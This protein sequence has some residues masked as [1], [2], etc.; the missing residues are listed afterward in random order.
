[1]RMGLDRDIRYCGDRTGGYQ[2]ILHV[3]NAVVRL[4]VHGSGQDTGE[5]LVV[6]SRICWLGVASSCL[7]VSAA[8]SDDNSAGFSR[9]IVARL[10][11]CRFE[12]RSTREANVSFVTLAA[13]NEQPFQ[14]RGIERSADVRRCAS[15]GAAPAA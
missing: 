13:L 4:R 8:S 11:D 3:R 15:V 6:S 1:M 5:G 14:A 9:R 12:G 10:A 2:G 7:S